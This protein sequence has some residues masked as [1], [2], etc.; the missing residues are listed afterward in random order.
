LG[1]QA[2]QYWIAGARVL[3]DDKKRANIAALQH[4]LLDSEQ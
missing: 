3:R 2:L 1:G 4:L